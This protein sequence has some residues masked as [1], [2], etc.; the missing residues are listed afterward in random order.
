MTANRRAFN[1]FNNEMPFVLPQPFPEPPR[2]VNPRPMVPDLSITSDGLPSAT[3]GAGGGHGFTNTSPIVGHH[4]QQHDWRTMYPMPPVTARSP[5]SPNLLATLTNRAFNQLTPVTTAAATTTAFNGNNNNMFADS[6]FATDRP[7]V[8]N[9]NGYVNSGG[10]RRPPAVLT[11]HN[12]DNSAVNCNPKNVFT[13]GQLLM[14]T[15]AAVAADNGRRK[16]LES[17]NMYKPKIVK[18]NNVNKPMVTGIGVNAQNRQRVTHQLNNNTN[19]NTC[20]SHAVSPTQ[21]QFAANNSSSPTN[22]QMIEMIRQQDQQLHRISQQIKEL[23]TLHKIDDRKAENIEKRS[24]QTMTSI[25]FDDNNNLNYNQNRTPLTHKPRTNRT[26]TTTTSTRD[27]ATNP[28]KTTP[29][30]TTTTT[31]P[32]TASKDLR[33][34]RLNTISECPTEPSDIELDSNRL[35]YSDNSPVGRQYHRQQQ[36]QRSDSS[37]SIERIRKTTGDNNTSGSS[38]DNR[39][40]DR[41]IDDI[42]VMLNNSYDT[43]EDDSGRRSSCS[44][45]PPQLASSRRTHHHQQPLRQEHHRY[46]VQSEQTLYIKRL[47]A[48]YMVNESPD[49]RHNNN[50]PKRKTKPTTKDYYDDNHH[51]QQQQRHDIHTYGLTRNASIATKNYLEKYGLVYSPPKVQ[52][53]PQQHHHRPQQQ[54]FVDKPNHHKTNSSRHTNNHHKLINRNKILDIEALRCQPKLT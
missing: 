21:Q 30:P 48:K 43:E 50:K 4:H 24:V 12:V 5:P 3:G 54:L 38:F 41:M 46:E 17:H 28:T 20:A 1:I 29:S 25:A 2:V 47:A 7:Q 6:R 31:T 34:L 11:D 33:G 40:Y 51:H 19:H 36:Q 8:M 37:S 9:T 23:L 44:P 10:D 42:H 49:Y 14:P 39:F 18:H 32:S 45:S 53:L 22:D 35:N 52:P 15:A 16:P 13:N 26:K 27:M